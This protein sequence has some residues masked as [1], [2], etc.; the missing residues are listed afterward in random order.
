[1]SMAAV[2]N[3]LDKFYKSGTPTSPVLASATKHA[4]GIFAAGITTG[5][6]AATRALIPA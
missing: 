6:R 5:V 4:D 3:V 1:M 2:L